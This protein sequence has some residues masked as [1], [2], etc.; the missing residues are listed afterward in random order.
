MRRDAFAIQESERREHES[1][2]AHRAKP[3]RRA[4]ATRRPPTQRRLEF[5]R[6]QMLF[7]RTRN[8]AV[9]TCVAGRCA[10]GRVFTAI[11]PSLMTSPPDGRDDLE[12]IERL[13]A[14]RSKFGIRGM[15]HRCG[16]RKIE[17]RESRVHQESDDTRHVAGNSTSLAICQTSFRRTIPF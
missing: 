12:G 3:R 2:R 16:A 8:K 1:T 5:Q 15:K 11:P 13:A 7:V 6:L 9:C 10:S 14:A 4:G 17:Q